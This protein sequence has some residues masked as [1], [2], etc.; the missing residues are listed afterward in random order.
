MKTFSTETGGKK[1]TVTVDKIAQNANGN[2]IIQYGNTTV[3]ATATMGGKKDLDYFPLMVD[4][5]EKYYAAGKIKGSRF[6][7]R[8]TRPPKEAVL[9][10]RLI[11]R[12]IRPLF[13]ENMRREVQV[14]LTPLSVDQKNDADI[15]ALW[16]ASI[17]LT[18][19][20]IPWNGP[21]AGARVGRLFSKEKNKKEWVINPT[22]KQ[23][24]ESD[25][26][27]LVC[28]RNDRLIMTEGDAEKIPGNEVVESIKF[29]ME[30]SKE[31]RTFIEKI[32][33][34]IGKDKIDFT[35]DKSD[36]KKSI[37]SEELKEI[38]KNFVQEKASEY[39]FDHPLKTKAE[40]SEASQKI[41]QD[42]EDK[43][44]EDNIGRDKREKALG[45]V[46][47]LV[48]KEVSKAIL[49]KD[50]R[51]DG[52]DLDEVRSLTSEV[53]IIPEVHGSGLFSR[54]ETQVLSIVTLGGTDEKKY[55]DTME[56]S[57][58]IRFLHHYN[59]PP[60]SVGETGFLRSA[61][62][63]EIGHGAL[64]ERGIEPVL[65]KTEE[66][67]HTIRIVS[68]VMSSNG[69]SSMA[70]ACASIL[71]AMD[72]GIPISEPVA[73][74]A[75][76]IASEESK[77]GDG[78]KRYKLITDMQDLEDG[79]GGMDFKIIGTLD[80]V[81]AVQLDTKTMGLPF[82][83]VE[84][85]FVASQKARAKI[86]KD[87]KSVISEPRKE[88][89]PNAPKITVF[90]ISPKKIGEVI[91]PGGKVINSIIDEFGVEI[92]INDDGTVYISSS[93]KEALKKAEK[94][95]KSIVREVEIGDKFKGKVVGITDFGAF[96]ELTPSK[97]GL[98]HI[99]EMAKGH[100]KHPSDVVKEGDLVAVKVIKKDKGKVGLTMIN[101]K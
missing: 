78:F 42:L 20:D 6:I 44:I 86:L 60:Y 82:E 49:D 40:R 67:P 65:P 100:V 77:N 17:A 95:V 2:C 53:K 38:T 30:Y 69:S 1:L 43:L 48:C 26:D 75:M 34:K 25:L 80:K 5:E 13:D 68:E 29:G 55:L 94:R 23:R 33:K 9:S 39:L 54:G 89:A 47:E 28:S 52:R 31:I 98:V 7:K 56:K 22:Y 93:D 63:R 99:S 96:V 35:K 3:L 71:A 76:G 32:Q 8:E 87:M 88:L 64:V 81:T 27:I 19:S 90:E 24:E 16:G 45:Y 59:F 70:S 73:G 91:G 15:V 46:Y 50:Q 21:I 51:I 37:T 97:D 84:K 41:K 62:R 83:V 101:K 85:T 58:K 72:A 92:N 4:F 14:I 66:F 79:P 12:A 10:A 57:G 74:I 18:I 36:D 11:D 61:S